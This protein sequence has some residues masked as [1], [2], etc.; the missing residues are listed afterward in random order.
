MPTDNLSFVP[1][2]V[3]GQTLSPKARQALR[4]NRKKEAAVILMNE[5]GLTCVEAGDLLDVSAC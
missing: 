4:D 5:Y 2:L 1:L 3:T